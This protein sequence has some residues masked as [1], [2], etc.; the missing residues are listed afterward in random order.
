MEDNTYLEKVYKSAKSAHEYALEHLVK[1][2]FQA[3]T[4]KYGE[5]FFY[6]GSVSDAIRQGVHKKT[7]KM[8]SSTVLDHTRFFLKNT[9]NIVATERVDSYIYKVFVAAT[10]QE[11]KH[12]SEVFKENRS[13]NKGQSQDQRKQA[14]SP[15][16]VCPECGFVSTSKQGLG[17][18]RKRVHDVKGLK[19]GGSKSPPT[20]WRPIE[21]YDE[22]QGKYVC[23]E[24]DFTS[25]TW[26][27]L[28]RHKGIHNNARKRREAEAM[29]QNVSIEPR[30][31]RES[32]L[33]TEELLAIVLRRFHEA[34]K[35]DSETIRLRE[36]ME[37]IQSLLTEVNEGKISPLKAL[38]EIDEATRL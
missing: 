6:E 27:G 9:G 36:Q 24:C 34:S 28:A 8:P 37:L 19:S 26:N 38:A 7:G 13:K 20:G 35:E 5:G 17:V 18:H 31:K 29:G 4:V 25:A 23:P 1:K 11:P 21:Q 15:D 32:E 12:V 33:S 14:A 22:E 16:L 2:D 30:V 3:Q 10:W